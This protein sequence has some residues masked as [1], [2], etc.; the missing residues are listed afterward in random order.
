[1]LEKMLDFHET[2]E[3]L[4]RVRIEKEL[5]N[6][7]LL[8]KNKRIKLEN[9]NKSVIRLEKQLETMY[10]PDE[11]VYIQCRKGYIKQFLENNPINL[12]TDKHRSEELLRAAATWGIL[13]IVQQCIKA[14]V[15]PST[16]EHEAL[17]ESCRHNRYAE[18]F[19]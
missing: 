19:L 4:E 8:L 13:D 10:C 6:E 14:N 18:L 2:T 9:L 17:R 16:N 7:K 11:S 5:A 1:M 12:E 3:I 15:D